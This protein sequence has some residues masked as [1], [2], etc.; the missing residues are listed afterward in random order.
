MTVYS[1][2][3][4]SVFK[5]KGNTALHIAALAGQEQVVTEL[6]NYGAN[7]N[8]Q[9]QVRLRAALPV[10]ITGHTTCT[11]LWTTV[12]SIAIPSVNVSLFLYFCVLVFPLC[13][14]PC[15]CIGDCLPISVLLCLCVLCCCSVCV[16]GCLSLLRLPETE[17]FHS[18]LHGCTRKPSRGCEVSPG[19][20]SQSEHS[21][22]G[23]EEQRSFQSRISQIPQSHPCR[24]RLAVFPFCLVAMSLP[25]RISHFFPVT[26]LVF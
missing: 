5:Q 4:V 22:W 14:H 26:Q 8:A 15:V 7:V 16:C 3:H 13:V 10:V 25:S 6:V 20:W 23:T 12:V 9:S 19:E 18:T 11:V 17:G 1:C 21:N 24:S 2:F